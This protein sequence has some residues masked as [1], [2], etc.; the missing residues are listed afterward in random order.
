VA[1]ILFLTGEIAALDFGEV[2]HAVMLADFATDE[3]GFAQIK[4]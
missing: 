1:N 4:G 3:H 2:K